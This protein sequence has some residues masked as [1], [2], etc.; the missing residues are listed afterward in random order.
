MAIKII[1]KE[2]LEKAESILYNWLKTELKFIRMPE[3]IIFMRAKYSHLQLHHIFGS[4]TGKIICD[5][6]VPLT[7]TQHDIAEKDKSGTTMLQYLPRAINELMIY[8]ALICPE[9][10]I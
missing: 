2:T 7:Q 4:Y 8:T 9:G 6:V 1:D 10:N 5:L 3:Y